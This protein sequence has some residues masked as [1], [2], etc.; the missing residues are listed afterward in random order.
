MKKHIFYLTLIMIVPITLY[1]LS[2]K[3]V[4]PIPPD[5]SHAGITTIEGCFECHGDDKG[6]PR[7][8]S[9]PPKDQCFNCHKSEKKTP[10]AKG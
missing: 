7:K 4:V 10:A 9:H 3:T 8:K 6:N 1:I 2:L 5:D